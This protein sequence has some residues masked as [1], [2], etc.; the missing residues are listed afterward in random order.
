MNSDEI[1]A[2]PAGAM[3][4]SS[5]SQQQS[6]GAAWNT[7]KF[8]EEY[9]TYKNRLLDQ[10]FSVAD[11]PDPLAPWPPHPKQY[12]KGTDPELERNLQQLIA[13]VK[14]GGGAGSAA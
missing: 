9:E 7:N 14:A 8:R 12:P 1:M 11:Y 10:K 2:E 4:P 5:E 3:N 13:R 6:K